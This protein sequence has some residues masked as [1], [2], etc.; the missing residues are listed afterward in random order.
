MQIRE[1]QFRI[2]L[3]GV[4]H[5]IAMMGVDINVGDAR[6]AM[7]APQMLDDHA[8]IVEDA[9]A[10]GALARRV[11]QAGDRHEGAPVRAAHDPVRGRQARTHNASGR[12]EYA[13]KRGRVSSVQPAAAAMGAFDD[14][15]HV[16]GGVKELQLGR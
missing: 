1:D 14:E 10:R 13:A 8:A 9:E 11:M 7:G 4:E 5:A 15:T 6:N 16:V 12:L 2:V 3:E